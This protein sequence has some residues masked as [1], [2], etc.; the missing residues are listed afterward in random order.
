MQSLYV[1][2]EVGNLFKAYIET[3]QTKKTQVKRLIVHLNPQFPNSTLQTAQQGQ[4]V[5]A[6]T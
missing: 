1:I 3:Y 5:R 4:S 2:Y 6:K